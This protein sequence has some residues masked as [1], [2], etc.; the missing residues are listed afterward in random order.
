MCTVTVQ[1]KV[2]PLG[3]SLEQDSQDNEN[4]ILLLH[5]QLYNPITLTT[6]V[7]LQ[8]PFDRRNNS[9]LST[10]IWLNHKQ[11]WVIHIEWLRCRL[12]F[13]AW[14]AASKSISNRIVFFFNITIKKASYTTYSVDIKC[15]S[16]RSPYPKTN[17][18]TYTSKH[19]RFPL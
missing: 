18:G 13:S 16:P 9:Y 12:H 15:K 11:N 14:Y 8:M 3:G 1:K 7:I 19:T 6:N 2:S 10:C 4:T 17:H 5:Q